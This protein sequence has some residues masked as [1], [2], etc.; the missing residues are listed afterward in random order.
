[1]P[2]S[3][4]PETPV[5]LS[6]KQLLSLA[7]FFVVNTAVVVL[8][9]DRR[10]AASEYRIAIVEREQASLHAAMTTQNAKLE[11][12]TDAINSLAVSVARIRM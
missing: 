4:A 1:M 5:R 11:K 10:H 6:M 3:L 8:Y 2:D 12:L 9:Q 7:A